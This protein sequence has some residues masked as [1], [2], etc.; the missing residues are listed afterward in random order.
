MFPTHRIFEADDSHAVRNDR[1]F[2]ST[3]AA[4]VA[5]YDDNALQV[6]IVMVLKW[7]VRFH[8]STMSWFITMVLWHAWN[9]PSWISC[10]CKLIVSKQFWSRSYTG[11]N[12]KCYSILSMR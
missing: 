12:V 5:E 11:V 9:I 4:L 3:E 10:R 2:L 7:N 6:V 8:P 1:I